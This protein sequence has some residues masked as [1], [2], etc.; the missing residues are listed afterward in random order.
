VLLAG[1]AALVLLAA[2]NAADNLARRGMA[3]DFGF[4]GA[5]AGFDIPFRLIPWQVTDSYG[6]ALLVALVNT[7]V[8]SSLAVAAATLLGLAIALLRLSG[9]PLARA[10]ARGAV[11]LVRNTPQLV[12]LFF[13]Y[14]VAL[15]ALPGHRQSLVLPGGAYLNVRGLFLPAPQAGEWTAMFLAAALAMLLA[16]IGLRGRRRW[17]ML[18]AALC[19]GGAAAASIEGWDLPA[20]RGFNFAGGWRLPPELVAL[21]LGLSVYA[22]AFISEVIREAILGVA[23]GQW[24]AAEALGLKRGPGMRLVVLPQ[25]ART[26]VPPLTS[27]Y[28]N[29]I[30]SSSLGAA[31]AY[32]EIVQVF[33]RTVLNQSGRAIETMTITLGVFLAINLLVSAL[34]ALWS[35]RHEAGQGR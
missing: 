35:R 20:L 19:L 7:L 26:A 23:R 9:N 2:R 25:A 15:Q 32:P 14:V 17:L 5:I 21:W 18:L 33:T 10:L 28:L 8:V 4:L 6:R 24:E 12:Q 22:A 29:V 27:Q 30:K 11:E 3:V 16:A 13:W 31:I 34:L 1:I